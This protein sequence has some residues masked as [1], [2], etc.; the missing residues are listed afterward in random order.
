MQ[1]V[2]RG[3]VEKCWTRHSCVIFQN[4][5]QKIVQEM[6]SAVTFSHSLQNYLKM[7]TMSLFLNVF[8]IFLTLFSLFLR[9]AYFVIFVSF[10]LETKKIRSGPKYNLTF[11]VILLSHFEKMTRSDRRMTFFVACVVLVKF[12]SFADGGS[13]LRVPVLLLQIFGAD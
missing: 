13:R 6:T 7:T 4:I 9:S 3:R 1:C 5:L 11:L 8:D 2:Q 10:C 12:S